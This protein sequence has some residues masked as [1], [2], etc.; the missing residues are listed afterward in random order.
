M[1]KLSIVLLFL[2]TAAAHA[3]LIEYFKEKDGST[4]WQYLANWSSGTLIILL[5]FVLFNLYRSHRQAQKANHALEEIRNMLEQRVME[6]TATLDKSNQLLK[7]S[8]SL[9][10]DEITQHKETAKLLRVSETY[11]KD[12]LESM[13]LMLIGVDKA[14]NVTQWNK[15]AEK[16]TGLNSQQAIGKN[17]WDVYPTITLSPN[18]IL[19][20][21]QKNNT[22]TI[23]HCQ[24]GQYYFD[25][26]IYPL[27]EQSETGVV[28]LVDNVTQRILAEN[29]LI[30]RDKMSSMG[31]LAS[32]MA[33]DINTPLQAILGDLD[34]VKSAL[35]EKLDQVVAN[36]A[37]AVKTVVELLDD[38]SERGKQASGVIN[39]LLDFAGAHGDTQKLASVPVVIEHALD[40]AADVLS[41]PSGLKFRDI[42]IEKHYEKNLPEVPCYVP[43]LQQVF[44][45]LFRHACHSVAQAVGRENFIPAIRIDMM[46][47]YDALWIKVQHNGVG[48]T[49]EEQQYIFEPFFNKANNDEDVDAA[50]RLSFSY[51]I[52]TEHHKGH[53]AVT[54]DINVGTTF[55]I[56]LQLKIPG[57]NK[58][59][60]HA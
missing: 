49:Y 26:T 23:K 28:V 7:E 11:I 16:F 59:V 18:Q 30:Q 32:T 2:H 42:Q 51:F 22:V 6:R 46:E 57:F 12:I 48:L 27:S 47:C 20:V 29:M 31:E 40:L 36:N 45:S 25:I 54:S 19:D 53:M 3:G 10:E 17:L 9:L 5:S 33:H 39:N 4:N 24:R 8:N 50:K 37:E 52:I 44:F 38:A 43:E 35:V 60:H 55:H 56:Q 1:K 41:D 34:A 15:C 58:P 21:I 14:M 13:P